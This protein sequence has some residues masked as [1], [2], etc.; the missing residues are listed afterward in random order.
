[1]L[2]SSIQIENI[3]KSLERYQPKTIHRED[4][5]AAAV[6]IPLVQTAAGLELLF[7]VRTDS[8]EHHKGQIA[9]PGGARERKDRDVYDTALREAKEEIALSPDQVEMI[10]RIDDLSTPTGFVVSPVVGYIL[11][12]PVLQLQP[13]EVSAYFMAP[14]AFFL[15]AGNGYTREYQREGQ[16]RQV[17]FYDYGQYTI[18]GITAAIIRNFKQVLGATPLNN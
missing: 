11:S 5:I 12:L 13:E 17:W 15:E 14:L 9:F 2:Q 1:M 3:R 4:L 18:W 10:G 16:S 8:V 7:T 6:L